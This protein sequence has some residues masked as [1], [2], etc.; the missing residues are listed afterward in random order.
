MIE[1]SIEIQAANILTIILAFTNQ[2][3]RFGLDVTLQNIPESAIKDLNKSKLCKKL[4][5]SIG[6]NGD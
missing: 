2:H 5:T 6:P 3:E 1:N 4:I